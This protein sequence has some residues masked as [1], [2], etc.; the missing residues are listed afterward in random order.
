MKHGKGVL[1]DYNIAS[2][3]LPMIVF[4]A[5]LGVMV[6]KIV[7]SVVIVVALFSMLAIMTIT[8]FRKLRRI[9]R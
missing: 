4:G 1:V 2:M 8:T 5:S 7:P 9:Q 3:M 6:N